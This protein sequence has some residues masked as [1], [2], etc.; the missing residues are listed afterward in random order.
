MPGR[1][2]LR[3]E[4]V[5]RAAELAVVALLRLLDAHDV[6]LQVLLLRP[7]RA[8]DA[9]EHLVARIAAP[10]RA[11]NLHQL[12]YPELARRRDVRAA[13]EIDEAALPR[14]SEIGSLDG[15]DAMISA[16]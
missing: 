7:C 2:L 13:A 15:I 4:K 12:E 5:E 8:V 1:L 3:V 11:R 14:Y 6:R 16:L 10:V 9:L